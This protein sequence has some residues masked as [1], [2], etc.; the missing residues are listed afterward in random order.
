[1]ERCNQRRGGGGRS[2]NGSERAVLSSRYCFPAGSL[3]SSFV[4]RPSTGPAA[5]NQLHGTEKQCGSQLLLHRRETPPPPPPPP[6]PCRSGNGDCASR[7]IPGI[8]E[9]SG[10]RGAEIIVDTVDGWKCGVDERPRDFSSL[11]FPLLSSPRS[12]FLI[13]DYSK[14]TFDPREMIIPFSSKR[15][16]RRGVSKG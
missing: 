5:A 4:N 13:L 6:P 7:C 15:G 1:M 10:R 11:L 8:E 2:G 3:F 14:E 16:Q 9:D 12:L